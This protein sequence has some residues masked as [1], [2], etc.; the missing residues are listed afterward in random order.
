MGDKDKEKDELGDP[1]KGRGGCMNLGIVR[2]L[3][4]LLCVLVLVYEVL[5]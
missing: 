5:R 4:F 2:L 1:E 3:L